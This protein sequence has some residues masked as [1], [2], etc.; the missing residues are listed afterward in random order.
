[1][2]PTDCTGRPPSPQVV[3]PPRII[4][5]CPRDQFFLERPLVKRRKGDDRWTTSGG[6]KGSTE[7]WPEVG[8]VGVVKR[9][10][11][12]MRPDGLAPLKFAQ[13]KLLRQD[14]F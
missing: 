2:G 7:Y 14:T 6:K 12:V 5:D 9:Y 1:M 3:R 13:Y 11:R 8:S 10:G 4:N